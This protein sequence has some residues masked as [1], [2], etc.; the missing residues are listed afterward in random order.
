MPTKS[1]TKNFSKFKKPSAYA[2]YIKS[3]TPRNIKAF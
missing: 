1:P 3:D 2:K